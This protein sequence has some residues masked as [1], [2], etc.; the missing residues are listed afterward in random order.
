MSVERFSE[1]EKKKLEKLTEAEQKEEIRRT[2]E[3]RKEKEKL[4]GH[5]EKEKKLSFLK[6]LVERGLIQ[7]D[8]AERMIDGAE[9]DNEAIAGIFEKLDE[10][11]STHDID[12]IFPREFRVSKDE[13][14]RAL[15]DDSARKELL[16]KIDGSLVFIHDSLH[17]H[18]FSVMDFFLDLHG[19]ARPQSRPGAGKHDRY[20]TEHTPAITIFLHALVNIE[21]DP[22]RLEYDHMEKSA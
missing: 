10:I 19:G 13:Y 20:Q 3:H 8:T 5:L 9:L 18:A 22:V 4:M 21:L 14:L 1:T 16:V 6:S 7:V 17:P 12:R 11:E 15:R 2:L